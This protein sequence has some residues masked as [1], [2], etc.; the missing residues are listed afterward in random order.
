M[1]LWKSAVALALTAGLLIPAASAA[2]TDQEAIKHQEAVSGCVRLGIIGG[3]PEGDFRPEGGVTRAQMCKLISV[4]VNGGQ[5][6][7]LKAV[8]N[9]VTFTD[10]SKN[11]AKDYIAYCAAH[12]I[13]SGM[14]DGRFAPDSGVTATQAAK[15]LLVALGYDAKAE[16]FNDG[17]MWAQNVEH[18]AAAAAL[19]DGLNDVARDKPL[20]RDN[21]ARMIWNT[22]HA[23]EVE[24][25]EQTVTVEGEETTL[26]VHRDRLSEDGTL[27]TMLKEKFGLDVLPP[28][29]GDEVV[30]G[31]GEDGNDLPTQEDHL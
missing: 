24:Y 3:Y 7:D 25:V 20:S 13:V 23:C 15:M 17:P 14:G 6:P 11:W 10:I 30:P 27:L 21:A 2:F 19:Y 28:E 9:K 4:A 1:K 5:E 8:P 22:L 29:E 26:F 18:E 12:G 16:G 31:D